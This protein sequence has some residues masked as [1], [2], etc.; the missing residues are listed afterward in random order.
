MRVLLIPS[1]YS[2]RLGG[3]QTVAHN[4]AKHLIRKGHE[5]QVVTNRYPRCLPV[6]EDVD[7]V[8]VERILFLTPDISSL[9][10]KRPDLFLAS[11]YFY[12]FALW[13]LRSIVRSFRPD[14]VNVHFPDHQIPFALSLRRDFDVRLVV[15]LHGYD[16]ERVTMD[17][18][19]PGGMRLNGALDCGGA[20][21]RLRIILHEADAVTA[22]S[23]YLMDKALQI[24]PSIAKK[25]RVIRNGIDPIRFQDKSAFISA[26]PYILALGRLVHTKGFDMLLDAIAKTESNVDLIIAGDGEERAALENQTRQL[27]IEKRVHFFGSATPEQAVR[28]LNGCRF[29]VIPSRFE[30]FGIVALEA[31]LAGKPVLASRVGGLAE[32]LMD[33]QRQ[34]SDGLQSFSAGLSTRIDEELATTGQF[35][36]LV[37]PNVTAL[38]E[39]LN[40]ALRHQPF[41]H[42][43]NKSLAENY[44]WERVVNE[45][46]AVMKESQIC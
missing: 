21:N 16:V 37:E 10:R 27:N 3:V 6:R 1:A 30:S 45:Y 36:T 7:G 11:F 22:C 2:P 13:R 34:V 46:E 8:S 5:V 25:G 18:S 9:K 15:S 23:R 24:E 20:I 38:A 19:R 42:F 44:S 28:L 33:L 14:V 43:D 4:L 26:R 41:L 17:Q 12:P 29:V 32:L 39:G 31:A 40:R 35:T